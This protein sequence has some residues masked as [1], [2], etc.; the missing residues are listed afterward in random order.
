MSIKVLVIISLIS[1]FTISCEES[2]NP[3]GQY[4]EKYVLTCLINGNSNY[5]IATLSKSYFTDTF[6]PYDNTKD[7][8]VEGAEIRIWLADSVYLLKD[9]TIERSDTSRYSTPFKF[10]FTEKVNPE[11]NK[12]MEIEALLPSGKR[13]KATTFIP[14]EIAFN[15]GNPT[16][17]PPVDQ[18]YLTFSWRSQSVYTFYDIR[19]LVTYYK[20]ENNIR[21][22]HQAEVPIGYGIR[23]GIEEPIYPSSSRNNYVSY[24]METISKFLADIS[25]GDENK[26]NYFIEI[27]P[28]VEVLV[29][30]EAL[31]RYYSSTSAAINDLT[32]R[33]DENDYTNIDGGLGIFGTYLTKNYTSISF[34]ASYLESFGYNVIYN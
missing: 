33:L 21:I 31:S 34:V 7:P 4:K 32:V 25:A 23:G 29:M 9:S 27:K 19:I 17:I 22:K 13:L 30:D 28:V 14:N 12:K 3:F 1:F 18:N 26:N 2:F 20:K 15:N 6:N 5:Q 24:P 16:V 10:Y 8:S 11:P